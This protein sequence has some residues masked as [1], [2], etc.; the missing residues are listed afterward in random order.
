M[1]RARTA[2]Q[3]QP[4]EPEDEGREHRPNS[5]LG[6]MC[7]KALKTDSPRTGAGKPYSAA[8]LDYFWSQL[9][10]KVSSFAPSLQDEI[11][12]RQ[13]SVRLQREVMSQVRP[14]RRYRNPPLVPKSAR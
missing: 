8:D 5:V 13:P 14:A 3:P 2:R 6:G 1:A 10:L 4:V 7:L 9:E 11:V 12:R